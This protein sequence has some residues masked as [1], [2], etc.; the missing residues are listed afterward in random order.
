MNRTALV[1]IVRDE[2]RCIERCLASARPWVDELRV[3]DTGSTDATIDIAQR[4]GA[5]VDSYPWNDDFAAARNAALAH[6]DADW[7]LVLDADEWIVEGG[8]CLRRLRHR[9]ADRVGL[10]RVASA[11]DSVGGE[12]GEAPSWLPRVLPRGV[13]YAG[14]IHE[15]PVS[16]LPRERLPLVVGHDGYL[17]AHAAR[18][19]GRNQKLLA[20]ALAADPAD[21]YLHSQA[22]K[23]FEVQGRFEAAAPH[24][25]QALDLAGASASWR[26]DLVVR[27]LFT[28]KKLARFE[29]AVELAEREM[30]RWSDSP[31]FFFTL[32]D[33][34]L[35]WAAACPAR[36][37]GLLPMIES[38]WL[39]ALEIGE[40]PELADTVSGRG[41]FLAAHNLGVFHAS[42]GDAAKATHWYAL[43]AELRRGAGTP[44]AS[45]GRQAG[46]R[47]PA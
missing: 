2:A 5:R 8:E 27:T 1:M 10:I 36:A 47:A 24:Y 37:G 30:G 44:S 15:Q 34:L 26:H 11:Y 21:A 35:D 6:V 32:G 4:L 18:K 23:D 42:L 43:E 45:N 3:L 39:R 38:S 16:Q 12:P 20:L 9:G 7:C 14:R 29:A 22:G 33:L 25:R 28:L 19:R 31:D 40:R 41:S 13:R 46:A 17:D